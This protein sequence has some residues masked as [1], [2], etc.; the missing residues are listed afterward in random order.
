MRILLTGGSGFIG[1]A[2]ADVLRT[3]GADVLSPSSSDLN[4]LAEDDV[5]AYL[6]DARPTHLLHAAWRAVHGDVMASDDNKVWKDASIALIRRFHE[7]G[8]AK[9]TGL[10]SSAEYDWG[11]DICRIGVTPLAPA[12]AYGAAKH[13]L[14]QAI[15]AYAERSGLA[16][17]WPRVF[18]VYGPGEHESRLGAFIIKQLLSDTP[19]D[20]THGR[21]IRDYVYVSDVAEGVVAALTSDFQ[22]ETDL[23]SG[24]RRSVR[25]LVTEIGDQM[26]KA[27]LLN[28]GARPS[29]AHD[30]PVVLGDPSHAHAGLGWTPATP[31]PVGVAAEIDWGRTTFGG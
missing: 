7:A 13:A 24:I 27:H 26:G 22:G 1:R 20:L 12:T 2:C 8:G 6:R 14:H 16:Y 19:A 11:E 18:F 21:Q 5:A 3:R 28:F 29:P 31:L 9:V 30:A 15:A 25:E 17:A 10:G 23:A 4:L